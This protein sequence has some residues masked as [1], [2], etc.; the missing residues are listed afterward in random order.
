[1]I[2]DY[3]EVALEDGFKNQDLDP[4][5]ADL[6]F[7]PV[8]ID[9]AE[10]LSVNKANMEKFGCRKSDWMERET[11]VLGLLEKREPG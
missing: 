5:E 10:A 6:E 7:T 4:W 2:S 3:F 1:M 8:W 11:Y 9:V